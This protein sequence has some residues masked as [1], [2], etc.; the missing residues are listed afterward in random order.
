MMSVDVAISGLG[1]AD[2]D[3]VPQAPSQA[4]LMARVKFSFTGDILILESGGFVDSGADFPVGP[5]FNLR[6]E[7]D[8]VANEMFYFIDDVLIHSSASGVFAATTMEQVVLLSDNF[9]IGDEGDFDNVVIVNDF[10]GE[11]TEQARFF[12][13]KNFDDDN[14][15]EVEVTLSCNTGLPLEQTFDLSEGNPVNFVVGNFEQGALDCEISE[16]VPAG[17]TAS[18]QSSDN[19]GDPLVSCEYEDL[20]GGQYSCAITNSLEQVDVDVTK[21]WIDENPQFNGA[22]IAEASWSCSNVAFPCLDGIIFNGCDSGNLNFFGNPGEDSF[23]V[24]P[25][26]DGGTTCSVSEVEVLDSNVEIDD[27]ECDSVVVFPG[28]GG[29]CTIYNTRLYAGIPTLSQYGL[30][31]LALLMLGVG[32]VGFRRFV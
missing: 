3:V 18:Y 9:H 7:A 26:W 15:A 16:D 17:Y 4:M 20:S 19:V 32:L 24:Y 2:Y 8:P 5:Y 1:G 27:S 29:S 13:A 12:V 30:A 31:V 11:P 23:S 22:N 10:T 28:T 25:S 21:V 14:P 6:I